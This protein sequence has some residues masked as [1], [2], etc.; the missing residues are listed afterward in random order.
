MTDARNTA[1]RPPPR[2]SGASGASVRPPAPTISNESTRKIPIGT[3]KAH[4]QIGVSP[5]LRPTPM[6]TPSAEAPR[7]SA[8]AALVLAVLI[9]VGYLILAIRPGLRLFRA[10]V[11]DYWA[12]AAADAGWR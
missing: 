7:R 8:P 4:P 3:R 6:T 2:P 11:R 5:S 9:F 1:R 12:C 10:R